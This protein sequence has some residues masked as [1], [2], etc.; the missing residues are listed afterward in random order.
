LPFLPTPLPFDF[1]L[2]GVSSISVDPHKM[3][4]STIPAG[5]LL[6]RE[7]A[8]L[9]SLNICT[10]YLS[11]KQEY[12]L[13]GTRPGGPVAGALAVLDHLGV[14]GMQAIVEGCMKNTRRLIEGMETFGLPVVV[15]PDVNVAAFQCSR[16]PEGW[17]VSW[18]RRGHLRI[19]CMPHVHRG[20][21]EEFLKDIG[22]MYA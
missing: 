15:K 11:V 8:M 1:A 18:T 4:M 6:V 2:P 12:T 9:E 22:E 5:C 16:V 14:E 7:E 21:V 19:V 3:G 17:K 20:I 10:P 13:T